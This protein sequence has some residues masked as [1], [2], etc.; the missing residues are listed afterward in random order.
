MREMIKDRQSAEVQDKHDLLSSLIQA[1][2]EAELTALTDEELMGL[3]FQ[4][5]VIQA[6]IFCRKSL[7]FPGGRT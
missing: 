1:N 5:R 7:H 2:K 3:W 6:K 4:L